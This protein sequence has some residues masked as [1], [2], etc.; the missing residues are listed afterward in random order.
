MAVVVR[1]DLV[2]TRL[3]RSGGL[4]LAE[5][6]VL[7]LVRLLED[8]ANAAASAAG[9][10]IFHRPVMRSASLPAIDQTKSTP[11]RFVSSGRGSSS[12]AIVG[13]RRCRIR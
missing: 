5:L 6:A 1:V 9:A 4:F 8:F 7:V 2:K 12:H 13:W 10:A 3:E 11:R